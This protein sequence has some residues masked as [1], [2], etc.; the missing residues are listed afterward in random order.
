MSLDPLTQGRA[1]AMALRIV[2]FLAIMFT[3]IVILFGA[4]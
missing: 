4:Q 3:A 2:Q 1:K